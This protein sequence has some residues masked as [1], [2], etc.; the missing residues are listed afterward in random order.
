[1]QLTVGAFGTGTAIIT[2]S[3]LGD[4]AM[5]ELPR[6]EGAEPVGNPWR[7]AVAYA[8]PRGLA[9]VVAECR[10]ELAAR[11]WHEYESFHTSDGETPRLVAFTA[12]K[13]AI[14]VIVLILAGQGETFVSYQALQLLPVELPIADDASEIKLD[15]LSGHVEYHSSRD[16]PALAAFYREAYEAAGYSDATPERSD[17]G[18]VIFSDGA[19]SRMAVQLVARKTGGHR[20]VVGPALR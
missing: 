11:G 14:T 18:L 5:S 12:V 4:L 1:M 7:A 3:H 10:R 15:A 2:L 9:D 19:G 17:D 16:R 8:T 6:P 20:V 13:G